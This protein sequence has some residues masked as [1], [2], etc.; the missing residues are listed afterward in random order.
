MTRWQAPQASPASARD[1]RSR[2][3]T[4][5]LTIRSAALFMVAAR[6]APSRVASISQQAAALAKAF[7]LDRA[8]RP[9]AVRASRSERPRKVELISLHHS[10]VCLHVSSVR[11]AVPITTGPSL[12]ARRD[13]TATVRWNIRGDCAAG[14]CT[15]VAV[16]SSTFRTLTGRSRSIGTLG[17]SSV[18]VSAD[19]AAS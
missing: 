4:L 6:S 5:C 16:A 1:P 9:A 12:R 11:T 18:C 7:P 2:N 14:V 15:P 19:I 8:P 13:R 3:P 10:F 17:A